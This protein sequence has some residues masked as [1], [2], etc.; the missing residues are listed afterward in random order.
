MQNIGNFLADGDP[1]GLST[2][3]NASGGRNRL[4][5][6]DATPDANDRAGYI[7]TAGTSS[8]IAPLNPTIILRAGT[9]P[10][11]RPNGSGS[12]IAAFLKDTGT[13]AKINFVR[14][15]RLPNATEIATANG[16]GTFNGLHVVKIST[17]ALKVAAANTTNA[18]AALTPAQPGVDLQ[19][20]H[21]HLEPGRRLVVGEHHP[22]DPAGGFGHR[23]HLPE[24]PQGRQRWYRGD[25]RVLRADGAGERSQRH[26]Q[27]R[28]AG[29]RHRAVLRGPAQP[30]PVGLL[31][32]PDGRLRQH[33]GHPERRHQAAERCGQ[34]SNTR[35]LYIV[36]REK[37]LGSTTRF[38]PGGSLNFARALFANPGSAVKPYVASNDGQA[39]I[40]AGGGT[41][42]YVD[43]GVNPT[44][45]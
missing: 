34:Y 30:L 41:A 22:A 43:C 28:L 8:A 17:D 13:P 27:R 11:L 4:I 16:Q 42:V 3:A 5:A 37:D 40:E 36:F 6:F 20:R 18:P 38:Q 39:A 35:G 45:C 9:S 14:A 44:S 24:R 23:R 10:V 33:A 31:Q 15:S 7:P 1:D 12:G 26:H 21:P 19:V 32:G 29:R 2:G 25:H